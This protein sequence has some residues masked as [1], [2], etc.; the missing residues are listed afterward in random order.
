MGENTYVRRTPEGKIEEFWVNLEPL[1][2][3]NDLGKVSWR[4][5]IGEEV[6]WV[7][8]YI[9]VG[10][11]YFSITPEKETHRPYLLRSKRK[12]R[13]YATKALRKRREKNWTHRV[14]R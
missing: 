4:P 11:V 8:R 7:W 13:R 14:Q 9:E 10:G 3:E 2:Y 1:R 6:A 12:A 5:R